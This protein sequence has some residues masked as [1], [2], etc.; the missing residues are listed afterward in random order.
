MGLSL[1]H[2]TDWV[3]LDPDFQNYGGNPYML[4][5]KKLAKE[6]TLILILKVFLLFFLHKLFFSHPIEKVDRLTR[7]TEYL[8]DLKA[9]PNAN[10]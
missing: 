3:V 10:Q 6:L 5:N 9:E 8:F 4:T 7:T 2:P 1:S